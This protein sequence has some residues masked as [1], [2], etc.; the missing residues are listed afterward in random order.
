M[1]EKIF[2]MIGKASI[3]PISDVVTGSFGTWILTIT[4]GKHGIDDGGHIKIAWRDVTDWENPQFQEPTEPNFTTIATTG[5]ANMDYKFEG[6]GYIRP[7][8]PCLTITIFDGYLTEGDIVTVIYGDTSQGSIGSRAQTFVE[9]SFE[10]RILI[11][12]FGT[13]VYTKIQESP[14][15]RI[16]AGDPDKLFAILSSETQIGK[17]NWISVVIKDKWGNP[18]PEYTGTINFSTTDSQS[19]LP[20]SYIFKQEDRG[21]H[22][23]QALN[24][25][26]QE[27]IM[28]LFQ[29]RIIVI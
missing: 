29:M 19:I 2:A 13:G 1:K 21:A 22:R 11:D 5:N 17:S 18:T 23:F 16:I 14:V 28:L 24:F 3:E 4:I 20:K 26:P 9:D 15:L 27:S 12:S 7:W 8:R 6:F 10:F 25:K